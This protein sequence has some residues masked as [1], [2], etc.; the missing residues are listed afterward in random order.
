MDYSSARDLETKHERADLLLLALAALLMRGGERFSLLGTGV[1]PATG[2]A[3][4]NRLTN[5]DACRPRLRLL[6]RRQP[7]RGPR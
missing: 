3:A 1:P 5:A 2:R 6:K 4:F 7:Q